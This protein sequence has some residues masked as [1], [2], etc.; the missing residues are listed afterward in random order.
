MLD[1]ASR[2]SRG[3]TLPSPKKTRAQIIHMFKQQMFLLRGRLNV[4]LKVISLHVFSLTSTYQGPMVTGEINLTCDAWQ[5]DNTDAYF[6]VTGHWIEERAPGEWT[7]EHALLGFAQM[8]C[9][10]SGTHL[11]QMLYKILNRLDIVDKVRI[12]AI[13]YCSSAHS[14]KPRSVMLRATMRRTILRCFKNSPSATNSRRIKVL[15]SNVGRLGT[16]TYPYWYH[17]TDFL[18]AYPYRCLAHI[19]N[20]ATQAVIAARSKSKHYNGDPNDDHLPDDLDANERDEIGIVRA[21]C[22]MVR[23]LLSPGLHL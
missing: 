19:I 5:A 15:M 20:L 22:I 1:I 21:I 3:I 11:G 12:L 13:P 2:A 8:N 4:C 23:M 9:S 7:L 14:M 17:P 18:I 10:H 16:H 6:A